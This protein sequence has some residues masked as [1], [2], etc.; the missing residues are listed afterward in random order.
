MMERRSAPRRRLVVPVLVTRDER[1][2]VQARSIDLSSQ[3]MAICAE[4]ELPAGSVCGLEF[5]LLLGGQAQRFSVQAEVVYSL[6][7]PNGWNMGMKFMA[8][9][10]HAVEALDAYVR[11][12]PNPD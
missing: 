2:P 3:G 6:P 1:A 9:P 10:A 11:A 7:Q 4:L 5:G 8:A 12:D